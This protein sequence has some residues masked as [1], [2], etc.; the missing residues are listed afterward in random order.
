MMGYVLEEECICLQ[1]VEPFKHIEGCAF[2]GVMVNGAFV[3]YDNVVIF[4]GGDFEF[5]LVLFLPNTFS[6]YFCKFCI[7]LLIE[8]RDIIFVP[9][10]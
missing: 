4:V 7:L 3:F 6:N 10:V 5:I 2:L 9:R 8:L 1:L